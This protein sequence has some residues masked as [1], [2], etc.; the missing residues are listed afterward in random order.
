MHFSGCAGRGRGGGGGGLI[1]RRYSYSPP[2][3]HPVAP[4]SSTLL[5]YLLPTNVAT[6]DGPH[7]APR[8][9]AT[10]QS[11]TNQIRVHGLRGEPPNTGSQGGSDRQTGQ[12]LMFWSWGLFCPDPLERHRHGRQIGHEYHHARF[13]TSQDCVFLSVF[14]VFLIVLNQICCAGSKSRVTLMSFQFCN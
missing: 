14:F 6:C 2:S 1:L 5:S 4:V 8:I 12:R 7:S 10:S 11:R 13:Q 9:G 3:P